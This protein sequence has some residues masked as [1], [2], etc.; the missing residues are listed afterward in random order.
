MIV[1][2]QGSQPRP[3]RFVPGEAPEPRLWVESWRRLR[4][5][6]MSSLPLPSDPVRD[7][8]SM[9][10]CYSFREAFILHTMV[11]IAIL[12][13]GSRGAQASA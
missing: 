7:D 11:E 10:A 4:C 5:A 2:V 9:S 3:D 8:V 1:K 6:E 12:A 13:D